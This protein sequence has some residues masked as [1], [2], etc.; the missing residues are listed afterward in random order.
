MATPVVMDTPTPGET[1]LRMIQI[2]WKNQMVDPPGHRTGK[3]DV[4]ERHVRRLRRGPLAVNM[5]A[6]HVCEQW[7]GRAPNRDRT[8]SL[9]G[10]WCTARAPRPHRS[11]D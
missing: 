2:D 5:D 1:G 11:N 7:E 8:H 4:A 9:C 6:K 3:R 10:S